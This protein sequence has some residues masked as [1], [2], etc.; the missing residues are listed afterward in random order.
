MSENVIRFTEY[1]DVH[2]DTEMWVCH[3]CN[4]E[5]ISARSDYKTGCLVS[6]RDPREIHQPIIEGDY[7]FAPDPEWVRIIEFYC[8]NCGRQIETEYLPPGHPVTKDI[9]LDVDSI[10]SRLASGEVVIKDGKMQLATES[11]N[12]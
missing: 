10:K 6:A 3:S 1:L 7:S 12:V 9:E 4:H 11:E 5:L 8:P 2:L